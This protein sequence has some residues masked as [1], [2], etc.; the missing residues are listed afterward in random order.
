M[1]KFVKLSK[2]IRDQ[3]PGGV[4]DNHE[5]FVAF[6]EYY[7]EWLENKHNP[8]D[9]VRNWDLYS[10]VDSDVDA[11]VEEFKKEVLGSIPVNIL[12]DKRRLIRH[13]KDFWQSKGT[14]R[15]FKFLFRIL[16]N[17]DI[18]VYYP[19]E[20]IFRLSAGN[21]VPND[22]V[23]IMT[24][25]H[26][27]T[28]FLYKR[29][30]Q[31]RQI[32]PFESVE[33]SAVVVK[34]FKR[35]SG[36]I[37]Q[38]ILFIDDVLGE[39]EDGYQIQLI[40]DSSVREN[41]YPI[42]SGVTIPVSGEGYKKGDQLV[43]PTNGDWVIEGELNETLMFDT[44][45]TSVLVADDIIVEINDVITTDFEYD[46]KVLTLSSFSSGDLVK[47][48]L[49]SVPGY[50]EVDAVSATGGILGARIYDFPV[51]FTED[52]TIYPVSKSGFGAEVVFESGVLGFVPGYYL[53][54]EGKASSTNYL[55]DSMYY[56][57]YS[58]VIRSS[59]TVDKYA[60]IVKRVL[61]PAGM[62]M[63]GEISIMSL[64]SLII[65][66]FKTDI[67]PVILPNETEVISSEAMHSRVAS[68]DRHKNVLNSDIRSYQDIM[69]SDF[70]DNYTQKWDF[71]IDTLV[72]IE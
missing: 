5:N 61:H 57:E 50:I 51:G 37:L 6:L 31:V 27:P 36:R 67:Y 55:L 38:T 24:S 53:G 32:N 16:F 66:G 30:R 34:S 18:E 15:S 21:W 8:V 35:L 33:A 46:G 40:E 39:F 2:L 23:L 47:V 29:I 72:E 20:N 41:L 60:D 54:N 19:K 9:N 49:P 3:L 22:R 45:V 42:V 52:K 13:S 64:I 43:V 44:N 12:A 62:K 56:Q 25:T 65:R 14:D 17:E 26:E 70:F 1:S 68:L 71:A 11:F 63:F 10:S 59:L 28:E 7:Y 69:L 4:T 48:T 58:Y